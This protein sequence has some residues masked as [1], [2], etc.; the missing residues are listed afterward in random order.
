L[1]QWRD[2]DRGALPPR[3][4]LVSNYNPLLGPT[5]L[6]E[7]VRRERMTAGCPGQRSHAS[8][9]APARRHDPA[10]RGRRAGPTILNK[11][12]SRSRTESGVQRTESLRPMTAGF[13]S[14][15]PSAMSGLIPRQ[16]A[17][18]RPTVTEEPPPVCRRQLRANARMLAVPAKYLSSPIRLNP[19][20]DAAS[21]VY[22]IGLHLDQE[23][24]INVDE[25]RNPKSPIAAIA[26]HLGR[27][28]YC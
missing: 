26:Q 24:T 20:L 6:A 15:T 25:Q 18:R 2:N 8:W 12:L 17:G 22:G 19:Q 14:P 7:A 5:S 16:R 4:H 10:D 21:D 3:R 28:S 13:F 1:G 27:Y 9:R 11:D 23:T